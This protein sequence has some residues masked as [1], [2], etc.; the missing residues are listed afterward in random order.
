LK[1]IGG[2][3]WSLVGI[4]NVDDPKLV[5][6]VWQDKAWLGPYP[7]GVCLGGLRLRDVAL[8]G[9]PFAWRE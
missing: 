1:V 5:A 6:W 2:A 9:A 8:A 3:P 4:G 7:F